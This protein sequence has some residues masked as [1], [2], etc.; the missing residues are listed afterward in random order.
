MREVGSDL[1]DV[2]T[3]YVSATSAQTNTPP[4]AGGGDPPVEPTLRF[5]VTYK[6]V[7]PPEAPDAPQ[8]LTT[9]HGSPKYRN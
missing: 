2:L 9:R 1:G 8:G 3:Q 6:R 5:R 4:A 7:G